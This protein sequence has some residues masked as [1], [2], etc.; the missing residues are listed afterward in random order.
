[1]EFSYYKDLLV[2][3]RLKLLNKEKNKAIEIVKKLQ[4]SGMASQDIVNFTGLSKQ[5]IEQL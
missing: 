1:M 3:V 4:S 2:Q 5:E